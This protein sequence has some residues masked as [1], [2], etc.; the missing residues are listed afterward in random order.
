MALR[1][2][3][4]G[5][6][7]GRLKGGLIA[8]KGAFK[9]V[10]TEPSGMVQAVLAVF[11]IIASFYYRISVTEWMIQSIVI[12]LVLAIEAMNTAVEKLCDFVHK[13]YHEAIGFIKDVAAGGVFFTAIA[14]LVVEILIFWP[15]I[16]I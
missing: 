12:A 13:E 5:F 3:D 14:A 2:N 10:T 8:F 15:K 16:F 7:K 6:V 1:N 11:I 4:L 9:F